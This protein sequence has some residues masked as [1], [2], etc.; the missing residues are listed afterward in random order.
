M[1]DIWK[2]HTWPIGAKKEWL[3]SNG[4]A[5]LEYQPSLA[6]IEMVGGGNVKI[7]ELILIQD[8]SARA[9][10]SNLVLTFRNVRL[11]HSLGDRSIHE[12]PPIHSIAK[13]AGGRTASSYA[14]SGCG[15]PHFR[16]DLARQ[17]RNNL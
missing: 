7:L 13:K 16:Q 4:F 9:S 17:L 3:T 15:Y 12:R 2:R 14:A 10:P 5:P 8:A 1:S 6:H 11:I